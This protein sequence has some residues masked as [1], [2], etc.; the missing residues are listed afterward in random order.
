M[1]NNFNEFISGILFEINQFNVG[2]VHERFY[3][4]LLNYLHWFEVYPN[5]FSSYISKS[6]FERI[7][8]ELLFRDLDGESRITY[9]HLKS[10]D[11]SHYFL[12]IQ[13]FFKLYLILKVRRY[14][15]SSDDVEL[16]KLEKKLDV[17][18]EPMLWSKDKQDLLVINRD[19]PEFKKQMNSSRVLLPLSLIVF[20]FTFVEL[21]SNTSLRVSIQIFLA[22]VAVCLLAN[23]SKG[24]KSEKDSLELKVWDYILVLSE[25]KNSLTKSS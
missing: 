15:L 24:A 7:I 12:D 21:I 18:F 1:K 6:E 10:L 14:Q 3:I 2:K 16:E 23:V 13:S 4:V 20:N 9:N 22:I 5:N 17:C 11:D 19:F 25:D 8:D